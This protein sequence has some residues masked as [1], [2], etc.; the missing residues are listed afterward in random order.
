MIGNII[1][2]RN[3]QRENNTIQQITHRKH[4]IL[5]YNTKIPNNI[6]Q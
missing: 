5:I 6:F 1:T 4:H 3:N 2:S